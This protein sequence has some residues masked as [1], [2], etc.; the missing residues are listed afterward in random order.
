MLRIQRRKRVDT[1]KVAATN[2][3]QFGANRRD[4]VSARA[5]ILNAKVQRAALSAKN[6]PDAF[7]M[8]KFL[9]L[10]SFNAL[11]TV[12]TKKLLI[13]HPRTR[14]S[15]VQMS[16]QKSVLEPTKKKFLA[17]RLQTLRCFFAMRVDSKKYL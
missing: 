14:K 2:K 10:A 7:H 17:Y 3:Q 5:Y 13:S 15:A 12:R 8:I 9:E 4:T 16:R 11:K 1:T 6:F